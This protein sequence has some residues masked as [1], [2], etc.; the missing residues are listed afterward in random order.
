[1][2]DRIQEIREAENAA[3][4]RAYQEKRNAMDAQAKSRV[5][6]A[7][8]RASGRA[9]VAKAATIERKTRPTA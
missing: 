9:K 4:Q 1:M 6:E 7:A 3:A 2:S 8:E 5:R